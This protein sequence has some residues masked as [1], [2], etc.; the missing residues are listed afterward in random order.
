M[1]PPLQYPF[2]GIDYVELPEGISREE[3][4]Y[5]YMT[6]IGCHSDKSEEERR[7]IIHRAIHPPKDSTAH[8]KNIHQLS[9]SLN[10]TGIKD[11]GQS[12]QAF[13]TAM[14]HAQKTRAEEF[15]PLFFDVFLNSK[16]E[17]STVRVVEKPK[18]KSCTSYYSSMNLASRPLSCV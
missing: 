11:D 13:W 4:I 10:Q 1:S 3:R 8:S 14:E 5:R 2:K 15:D 12:A 7:T 16:E 18:P 17:E 9:E 6:G